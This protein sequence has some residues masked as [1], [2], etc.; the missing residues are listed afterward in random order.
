M[1]RALLA[2]AL[3]L[4]ACDLLPGAEDSFAEPCP[5]ENLG[6]GA[7]YDASA[8]ECLWQAYS[9]GRAASFT[10]TRVTTEGDPI[11]TRVTVRPGQRVEVFY[12]SSLDTFSNERGKHTLTCTTFQRSVDA[13]T[14]RIRF[15]ADNCRGGPIR[16]LVF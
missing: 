9:E 11:T 4:G 16:A 3:L 2:A 8:R 7:G 5:T 13:T 10:T 15:F 14:K 6:T 1:P 12:D